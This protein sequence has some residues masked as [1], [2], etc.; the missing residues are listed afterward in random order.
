MDINQVNVGED[1][2]LVL[3]TQ[4][5]LKNGNFISGDS[6]FLCNEPECIMVDLEVGDLIKNSGIYK[7]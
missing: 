6:F 1:S 2:D 7:L 5:A 4:E 3:Y